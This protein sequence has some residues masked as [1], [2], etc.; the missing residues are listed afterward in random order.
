MNSDDP[1]YCEHCGDEITDNPIW[2][3]GRPFHKCCQWRP[4]KHRKI[5]KIRERI[6]KN[7]KSG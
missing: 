3:K 7:R 6:A 2:H 4:V 5:R 1:I